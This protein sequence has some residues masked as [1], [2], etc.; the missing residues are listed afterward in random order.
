MTLAA[1]AG[2]VGAGWA[3]RFDQAIRLDSPYSG[4]LFRARDKATGRAVQVKVAGRTAPAARDGAGARGDGARQGGRA[5]ARPDDVR[6]HRR[7]PDGRPG[8]RALPRAC[9]R[10]LFGRH[11]AP[12]RETV[13]IGVKLAGALETIHRAGFVH[14]AVDPRNL[15]LTEWAEPVVANLGTAVPVARAATARSRTRP[16]TP[17][18]R[19]C[20]ARRSSRRPTS[21][22]W[23][24]CCT[25]CSPAV[26]RSPPRPGT[27]PP[28]SARACCARRSRRWCRP[29]CPLD[30]SDLLVWSLSTDSLSRPPSAIWFGEELRRIE[31]TH[32]WD[33]TPMMIESAEQ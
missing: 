6:A 11:P 15:L 10:D 22:A 21:T 9:S 17:R 23:R 8:V 31:K 32:G 27:R 4:E 12:V 1:R 29:T 19:C 20:S 5:P 24:R 3:T 16:C 28:R 33:R 7:R 2:A 26:R 25:C 30:L 13:T 14:S 18:R